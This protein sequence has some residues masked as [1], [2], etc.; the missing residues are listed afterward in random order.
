VVG[1]GRGE[2]DPE[3]LGGVG[4]RGAVALELAPEEGAQALELAG[5]GSAADGQ[6][7]GAV[8]AAV[9]VGPLA[10]DAVREDAGGLDEARV[11]EQGQGLLRGVADGADGGAL[12]AGGRVEV[13]QHRVEEGPLPVHVEASAPLLIVPAGDVFP[14]GKLEGLVIAVGLVGLG[15]RPPDVP[16]VEQAG[17]GQ[18]VV[19]HELGLEPA[20]ILGR[21]QAVGGVE[22]PQLGPVVA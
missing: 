12:V 7:E 14:V 5:A 11:V 15:A 9:G 10:G 8:E 22:V 1:G 2:P 18:G 3:Q 13:G 19:A 20:G 16:Q 21:E 6:A 17:D 4:R